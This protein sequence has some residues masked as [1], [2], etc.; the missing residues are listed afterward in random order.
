MGK[1]TI[2]FKNI[3]DTPPEYQ[4]VHPFLLSS[5]TNVKLGSFHVFY[6]NETNYYCEKKIRKRHEC[7]QITCRRKDL[8]VP[9][10]TAFHYL[11]TRRT[12]ADPTPLDSYN[13]LCWVVNVSVQGVK[14][15]PDS[16]LS[17]V[18]RSEHVQLSRLAI[19]W[20]CCIMCIGNRQSQVL[21]QSEE[22]IAF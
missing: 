10:V 14:I 6:R 16:S 13:L 17:R 2:F 21:N 8:L 20:Q 9:Y 7:T 19:D 4:M 15:Q 22:S 12:L 1:Q 11:K 18:L 3:P 5:T